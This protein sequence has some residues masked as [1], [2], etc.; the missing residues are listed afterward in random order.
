MFL[1]SLAQLI[2]QPLLIGGSMCY[3]FS[4]LMFS[5][6]FQV[7]L[8]T[9]KIIEFCAWLS[10]SKYDLRVIVII[11]ICTRIFFLVSCGTAY[12]TQCSKLTKTIM[13]KSLLVN[14]YLMTS[15]K[16]VFKSDPSLAISKT[17]FYF[18]ADYRG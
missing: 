13:E 4:K 8:F 6:Y 17:Y 16:M 11:M 7:C 14:V 10:E 18:E 2:F 9:S 1:Y 15:S 3:F 12:K 5:L